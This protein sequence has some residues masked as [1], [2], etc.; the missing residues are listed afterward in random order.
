MTLLSAAEAYSFYCSLFSTTQRLALTLVFS[1]RF[2][3]LH[4]PA[5]DEDEESGF[6]YL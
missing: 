4:V 2:G 1:L 3:R 6:A 5:P